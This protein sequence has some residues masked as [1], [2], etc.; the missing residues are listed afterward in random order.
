MVFQVRTF[1]ATLMKQYTATT[2]ERQVDMP[3][4]K[5]MLEASL[6]VVDYKAVEMLEMAA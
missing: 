1:G 4:F 6:G 3:C 2:L 5:A